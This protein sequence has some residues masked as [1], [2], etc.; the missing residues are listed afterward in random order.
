VV[1]V[2]IM[3][4][5]GEEADVSADSVGVK[6]LVAAWIDDLTLSGLA[7]PEPVKRDLQDQLA[8]AVLVRGESGDYCIEIPGLTALGAGIFRKSFNVQGTIV[9]VAPYSS[10][11]NRS[12]RY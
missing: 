12:T 2:L 1:G 8:L 7:I 6:K 4:R 11:A 3:N 10:A 9:H 5:S